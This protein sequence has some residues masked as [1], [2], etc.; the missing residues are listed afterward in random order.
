MLTTT[1]TLRVR[2]HSCLLLLVRQ[3]GYIVNLSEFYSDRLIGKLTAFLQLQEF[4]LCRHTQV[5]S[6]P[7]AA[8]LS[9]SSYRAKPF[10]LANFSFVNLVFIF[11]CSSTTTNPVCARRVNLLV[12][13]LSLHRHSYIG[14]I[15]PF[16]SSI[17]N[18]QQKGWNV[19]CKKAADEP[20][21][22]D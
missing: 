17:H 11:R 4:S 19:G 2:Y 13:S 22:V 12:Y 18:K 10:T 8:R 1:T 20:W 7:S 14:F 15:L 9:F 21:M 6:S 3:A 5:A 16:A